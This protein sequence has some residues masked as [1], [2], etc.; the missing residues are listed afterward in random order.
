MKTST[1]QVYEQKLSDLISMLVKFAHIFSLLIS[2]EYY[3]ERISHVDTKL[4][5]R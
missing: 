1:I 5:Q 4:G 3:L 2:P